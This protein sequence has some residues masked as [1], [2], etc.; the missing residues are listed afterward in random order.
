MDDGVKRVIAEWVLTNGSLAGFADRV[1]ETLPRWQTVGAE[2]M[3]VYRT[4]GGFIA[5]PAGAP[6][7]SSLVLG[8]RPVL[9]TSRDPRAIVR[10]ADQDKQ[11][12]IFKINLAPGTRIL[13][14]NNA[15]TFL[16]AEGMPALAIKNTVLDAVR[17][18]CPAAGAFP[19]KTTPLPVLRKAILDRCMGRMKITTHEYI[20]AEREIMVD[21]MHGELTEPVPIEPIA[22]LTAFEVTYKPRPIGGRRGRTFRR[23][24]LRK[25]KNGRRLARQSQR[26]LRNSDA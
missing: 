21:G 20:P 9:A 13:D 6:P 5:A 10:Y 3:T 25:N 4:Q 15:V 18:E 7:P 23:K 11:C 16:D 12:C 14:V 1:R 22:G 19:G 26:R 24:P 2:G 17:S 8:V